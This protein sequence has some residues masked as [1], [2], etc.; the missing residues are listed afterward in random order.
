MSF[1]F[2]NHG[3]GKRSV[4]KVL[5]GFLA[6]Q[7]ALINFSSFVFA[8]ETAP[9]IA[10]AAAPVSPAVPK[11][12]VTPKIPLVAQDP[13]PDSES[14]PQAEAQTVVKEPAQPKLPETPAVPS[15]PKVPAGS[16]LNKPIEELNNPQAPDVSSIPGYEPPPTEE[17]TAPVT[18][19]ALPGSPIN[20]TNNG[21]NDISG[22]GVFTGESDGSR[23]EII[24]GDALA[25]ANSVKVL[26]F[27]AFESNGV[28][29][30]LNNLF[31][32]AGNLDL[33]NLDNIFANVDYGVESRKCS[34]L[35]CSDGSELSTL[36]KN[37][38]EITNDVIIRAE[39][40]ANEINQASGNAY[41]ETGNA[42]AIGN[43]VN[44]ANA[45]FEYANYGVVVYNAVNWEG[46][47][48]LPTFV[49]EGYEST[50]RELP[51]GT[52]STDV[53]NYN[54]S[55]ITNNTSST[56]D[57][58][59][60][61]IQNTG[62]TA[63]VESGEATAATSIVTQANQ[64]FINQNSVIIV[65]RI[66]GNWS[67][68]VLNTPNGILWE[69]TGEG[70][71]IYTPENNPSVASDGTAVS[72]D[73]FE[74]TETKNI[75]EA[76]ITNNIHAF[77]LTGE[78][79]LANNAGDAHVASGDA[80]SAVSI[81]NIA[82]LNVIGGNFLLAIINIFN[83]DG[84][85]GNVSFGQPD[86]W[87]GGR[88]ELNTPTPVPGS[89]VTY[90][91]TVTNKGDAPATDVTLRSF[92]DKGLIEFE[93]PPTTLASLGKSETPSNERVWSLGTISPGESVQNTFKGI[94]SGILPSGETVINNRASVKSNE[95]DGNAEDNS[96]TVTLAVYSGTSIAGANTGGKRR[97]SP[98]PARTAPPDF[99]LE[100]KVSATQVDPGDTVDFE[101]TLKNFGAWSGYNVV[102][103]D[104]LIG[105]DGKV[106]NE[107]RWDLD[108]VFKEETILISYTIEFSE[109]AFPG[110]YTNDAYVEALA[111]H[112]KPEF[113]YPI[114]SE[115][116][117]AQFTI[118]G[119]PIIEI[120]EEEVPKKK[121]I[122]EEEPEKLI[123]AAIK[124][125]KNSPPPSA[126][127]TGSGGPLIQE[128]A[129]IDQLALAKNAI[130]LGL[131]TSIV[132]LIAIALVMVLWWQSE[133]ASRRG[134]NGGNGGNGGS[135][136]HL[137]NP[138]RE[139]IELDE[140]GEAMI[141]TLKEIGDLVQRG[142]SRLISSITKLGEVIKDLLVN[143][144]KYWTIGVTGFG[145]YLI[146]F[147]TGHEIDRNLRI[148]KT[149]LMGSR[150]DGGGKSRNKSDG[151]GGAGPIRTF[152][153]KPSKISSLKLR[154]AV[155]IT[156]PKPRRDFQANIK[157]LLNRLAKNTR[158]QGIELMEIIDRTGKKISIVL[159]GVSNNIKANSRYYWTRG[160]TKTGY[161]IIKGLTGHEIEVK[162]AKKKRSE[163]K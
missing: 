85:G 62:G 51:L 28:F 46:D 4:A 25:I 6:L 33:R 160:I 80:F 96:D 100:K 29:L 8:E 109:G 69:E 39:T 117:A 20:A 154:S 132:F 41:V 48:I 136:G 86:L 128:V 31:G 73:N 106:I 119:E 147:L 134:G 133:L 120:V 9:V 37:T 129:S 107:Q 108:E 143:A 116:A 68:Q 21:N 139:T 81:A 71:A 70:L 76:K 63:L 42:A 95:R 43:F 57:T 144:K 158:K 130:A 114:I 24:T 155:S 104:K 5:I 140:I 65:F 123:V 150:G 77:A 99:R 18:A 47:V 15:A 78:N 88:A 142:L 19:N 126:P 56:A 55:E 94:V 161:Y 83:P 60:N 145:Y 149:G 16:D 159:S 103:I 40:G 2:L 79:K 118:T 34:L 105:P 98:N 13:V 23:T 72:Y 101:I 14:A 45:N 53:T 44:V 67:G 12:P 91:Y 50:G 3:R 127:N 110:V 124:P 58:G 97:E 1:H 153:I 141:L 7:I 52:K 17:P 87:I 36:N 121:E 35:N 59:T 137:I 61:A 82:N 156:R 113:G 11:N 135:Q 30:L 26:N 115:S 131:N 27:N 84:W 49:Q 92:F 74:S 163:R 32:V 146:K 89:E 22:A 151:D 162:N 10:E 75:N 54:K 111:G 125:T 38:A 102:L 112:S 148:P 122:A 93:K 152:G 157:K 138:F 66:F 64:T 90:N